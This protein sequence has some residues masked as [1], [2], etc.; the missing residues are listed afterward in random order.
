MAKPGLDGH[1]NGSEI[2]AVAAK[3]CGFDVIYPGIRNTPEEIVQTALEEDV[4]MLAISILSGSHLELIDEIIFFMKK[5]NI[6]QKIPIVI[7]GI[8]PQKD[9]S[10]LKEKKI[11]EIYTPKDFNLYNIMKNNLRIIEKYTK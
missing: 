5:N 8:I 2:I 4:S 7:G 10:I 6:Y 9:F 1:S 11:E 3:N